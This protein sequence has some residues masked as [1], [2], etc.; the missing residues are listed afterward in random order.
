MQ[1]LSAVAAGRKVGPHGEPLSTQGQEAMEEA[2]EVLYQRREKK[3]Q[4]RI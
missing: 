2:E 3:E 4:E 1:K